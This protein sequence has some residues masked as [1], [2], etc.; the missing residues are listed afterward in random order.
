MDPL[1]ERL[2]TECKNFEN[3]FG[4]RVPVVLKA[5]QSGEM[6]RQ[7]H[8]GRWAAKGRSVSPARGLESGT[9]RRVTVKE[10]LLGT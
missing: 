5:G 7:S 8:L 6:P 4:I 10:T 2:E 9:I 3:K 1:V